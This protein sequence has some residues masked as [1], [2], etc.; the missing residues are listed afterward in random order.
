MNLKKLSNEFATLTL[1]QFVAH[2]RY[3]V[4]A[5]KG[6]TEVGLSLLDEN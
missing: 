3:T 2:T 6:D 1:V 5:S 4:A